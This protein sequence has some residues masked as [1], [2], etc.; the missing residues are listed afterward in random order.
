M[1]KVIPYQKYR[2]HKKN[3]FSGLALKIVIDKKKSKQGKDPV[4]YPRSCKM[5][6]I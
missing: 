6:K 4:F 3:W 5:P 1:G 2:T